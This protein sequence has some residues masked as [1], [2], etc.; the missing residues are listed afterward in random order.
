M[1]GKAVVVTGCSSGIGRA[2]AIYL[3]HIGYTVFATVRKE[4]DASALRQLSEPDLVP[5]WPLD[6]GRS[7]H[8]TA[9]LRVIDDELARRNLQGLHAIVNNAGGGVVA[10]LELLD[11]E[12][13]RSE[14]EARVLG[15]L[16]LLQGALPLIRQA[17][18]RVV[19]IT[20][21]SL[22]PIPFVASIHVPDFAV[23]GLARTLNLELKRWRIPSIMV[24]CGTIQ[25]AAPD[26][27]ARELQAGM[28]AWPPDRLDLY[29]D[30]LAAQQA[31]LA[32]Y[33]A[34]RTAPEEV[35][36]VVSK[37][38]SAARPRRRYRVGRLSGLA[39]A[40]ELLPQSTI[41]FIMLHR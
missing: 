34:K 28:Q 1:R 6:L 8:I 7:D 39:A 17:Q 30:E 12:R 27:T 5:V 16:A 40:V 13:L 3:A 14:F 22:M 18:G 31:E 25:T 24:R 15:P 36:R 11:V 29:R 20:T 21:P 23:N 10:P 2:T 4:A 26:R 37:A 38:L 41:D 32:Q 19:W 33:D 35:A 9:A